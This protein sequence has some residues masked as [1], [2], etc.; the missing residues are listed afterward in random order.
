MLHPRKAKTGVIF[1]PYLRI[2]GTSL[3]RPLFSVSIVERFDC[4]CI[5]VISPNI[6]AKPRILAYLI[7]WVLRDDLHCHAFVVDINSR[8]ISS[9]K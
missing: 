5:K 4:M 2:T 8:Q 6:T 9:V 3:H 1:H 7:P